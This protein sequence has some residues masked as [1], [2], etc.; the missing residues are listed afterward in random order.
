MGLH[1]RSG[2]TWPP[3]KGVDRRAGGSIFCEPMVIL[4]AERPLNLGDLHG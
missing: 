3:T 4:V 2:Q 1:S